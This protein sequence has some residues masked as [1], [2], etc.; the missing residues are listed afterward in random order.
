MKFHHHFHQYQSKKNDQKLLYKLTSFSINLDAKICAIFNQ[1]LDDFFQKKDQIN[2][3][4]GSLLLV[5]ETELFLLNFLY[6]FQEI[7]G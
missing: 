6:R 4:L 1:Y 2:S 3:S 5:K 7:L